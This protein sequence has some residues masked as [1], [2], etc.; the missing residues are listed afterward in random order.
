[1]WIVP[2]VPLPKV[3]NLNC[4]IYG[5]ALFWSKDIPFLY[6]SHRFFMTA[7]LI[8]PFSILYDI[9]NTLLF[10]SVAKWTFIPR[11]IKFI[12]KYRFSDQRLHLIFFLGW[13]TFVPCFIAWISTYGSKYRYKSLFFL[14]KKE[15]IIIAWIHFA[16]STCKIWFLSINKLSW[17]L[18]W[19]S[20]TSF[21]NFIVCYE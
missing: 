12:K 3:P 1:M 19:A 9:D 8:L 10:Q 7:D 14:L 18:S 15:I 6:M 21:T 4:A 16:F 2:K 17:I 5:Q 20:F 13:R 11:D